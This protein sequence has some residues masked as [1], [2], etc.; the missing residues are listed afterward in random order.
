MTSPQFSSSDP[1]DRL[2]LSEARRL[3][4]Y[5]INPI[6]IQRGSK[7]P[8]GWWRLLQTTRLAPDRFDELFSNSNIAAICGRTSNNLL[9]IDSDT[10][11]HAGEIRRRMHDERLP[12]WIRSSARGA[13]FWLR[14]DDGE[15]QTVRRDW[16]EIRGTGAYAVAP[17][18]LHPE[19]D[20]YCWEDEEETE[21]NLAAV[22][23]ARLQRLDLPIVLADASR[24]RRSQ[25]TPSGL[26]LTAH[27]V[28]VEGK[29]LEG[30]KDPSWSSAEWS[31]IL[32]LLLAGH[33]HAA[34]CELFRKHTPPHYAKNPRGMDDEIARAEAYLAE[35]P[36][37]ILSSSPGP[38][39]RLRLAVDQTPWPGRTGGTDRAVLLACVER[40]AMSRQRSPFRASQREVAELAAKSRPTVDLSLD[41]LLEAGYLILDKHDRTSG[42]NCYQLGPRLS[43]LAAALDM[44]SMQ[45]LIPFDHAD[46]WERNALGSSAYG[47]WQCLLLH[48]GSTLQAVA[49]HT[50]TERPAPNPQRLRMRSAARVVSG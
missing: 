39:Q 32:A 14:C 8:F 3:Y 24:K 18:S 30:A 10:Q 15:V 46:A 45:P 33:S 43:D 5:G 26:P 48:P 23:F 35:R 31:A 6:P 27:T 49:R 1:L 4:G 20:L 25:T 34:I 7:T 11:E 37:A 13:Q 22:S 47:I 40:Y 2:V 38:I 44:T 29:K 9:V 19:G 36:A 42:A 16:G 28:L 50:G 17:P 12:C 41:R 21:A